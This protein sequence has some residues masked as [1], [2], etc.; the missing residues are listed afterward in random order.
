MI[1]LLQI[2]WRMWQWKNFENR[3]VFDEVMCRL[4]RL[5]FMAHP[6]YCQLRMLINNTNLS[7]GRIFIEKSIWR[8]YR[9]IMELCD[10][11]ACFYGPPCIDRP[12][13]MN[14]GI[15][16]YTQRKTCTGLRDCTVACRA[17]VRWISVTTTTTWSSIMSITELRLLQNVYPNPAVKTSICTHWRQP[18]V[19]SVGLG[20]HRDSKTGDQGR[21]Q[22]SIQ[23]EATLLSLLSSP[24]IPPLL[25]PP[26]LS[27][28]PF[29]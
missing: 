29:P 9:P 22:T 4:R 21:N 23:E 20:V 6:V 3:P 10:L 1:T 28:F 26:A 19:G 8:S 12:T 18:R 7:C 16:F 24:L 5:T 17:D 14:N 13:R 2:S 25:S 15:Q 11:L 27:T